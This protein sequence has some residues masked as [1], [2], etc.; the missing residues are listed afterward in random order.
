MDSDDT[1]DQ[2]VD[3]RNNEACPLFSAHKNRRNDSEKTRKIIHSALQFEQ[4]TEDKKLIAFL[5]LAA[6]L[7]KASVVPNRIGRM[8]GLCIH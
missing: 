3:A 6:A 1:N 7:C 8:R 4:L 2:A 5:Y